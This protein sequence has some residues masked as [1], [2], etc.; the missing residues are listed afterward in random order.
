MGDE[1]GGEAFHDLH[2][3]QHL[4]NSWSIASVCLCEVERE[5]ELE[6]S[7]SKCLPAILMQM[8]FNQKQSCSSLYLITMA[9]KIT[10]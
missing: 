7:A 4:Q 8:L 9:I 3:I 2:L 1:L 5:E 10:F 6:N